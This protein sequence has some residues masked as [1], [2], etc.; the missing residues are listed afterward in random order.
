M[1][2]FALILIAA[3]LALNL[4][5]KLSRRK[6]KASPSRKSTLCAQVM[7]SGT[8]AFAR[9]KYSYDG[10]A[11][12][13]AASELYDGPKFC[14]YGCVGMGTCAA[15]CPEKAINIIGGVAA[16]DRSR[17]T[18]C[19]KCLSACPKGIIKLIPREK[20]CWVG[21]SSPA[22]AESTDAVCRVGCT[23]CGDCVAVCPSGAV[24]IKDNLA[25]TDTSLCTGCGE[26]RTA[27]TRKTIWK[28]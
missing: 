16:V 12:C 5:I 23:A 26:C 13:K 20:I 17:C 18:G 28:A 21:C 2:I 27:C 4:Y 8:H 22:E 11:D 7:C 1:K 15:V 9:R 25:V 14:S 19:G 10:I 6:N 3:A 24:K